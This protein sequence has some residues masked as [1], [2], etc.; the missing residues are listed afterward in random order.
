[1]TPVRPRF[2]NPPASVAHP[3]PADKTNRVP[4]PARIPAPGPAPGRPVRLALCW[5]GLSGYAAA[6]FRALA[7]RGEELG[8]ELRVLAK[9]GGAFAASLADG[10]PVELLSPEDRA[11]PAALRAR[12]EA[13]APDAVAVGGWATPADRALLK[14]PPA[15]LA[16]LIDT[17]WLGTPRQ[18]AG[19][20]PLRRLLRKATTCVVPGERGWQYARRLGF[21]E[22]RIFTGLY[23]VDAAALGAVAEAR[24]AAVAKTGEWPRRF[25]FAG[26]LAPEKDLPTLLAA[27]AAYRDR[28]PDPW[29][30]TVCGTGPLA[31]LLAGRPGVG[32][33][34]FVQPADLHALM[35]DSG[36]FALPSRFDPWPLAIVEACAAGL[37]VVCTAACG[38]AVELVRPH[39]SGFVTP[40]AD[41]EAFADALSGVHRLSQTPDRLPTW[42]RRARESASA[43]AANRWAARTAAWARATAGR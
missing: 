38:S 29:P 32:A 15:P 37:P 12:V 6:C 25:L 14:N 22:N 10:L 5:M 42:S 16:A 11:D 35:A 4:D 33:R 28:V 26:R 3:A 31:H 13:F 41:A 34:G 2:L 19:R 43:Y 7:V 36:A 39:H 24:D 17:P 20:L 9:G 8:V 40:T 23:G 1:M 21:A 30:L 18:W 27:Y